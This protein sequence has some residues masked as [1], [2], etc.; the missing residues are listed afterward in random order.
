MAKGS[1]N[2][3]VK[4]K[5]VSIMKGVDSAIK[6]LHLRGLGIPKVLHS[7]LIASCHHTKHHPQATNQHQ[8]FHKW[9]LRM[10]RGHA[11]KLGTPKTAC[12]ETP[13]HWNLQFFG[14]S[15]PAKS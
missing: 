2:V 13:C 7:H 5:G 8:V 9:R 11:E 4:P 15:T 12:A 6:G 10:G 1:A 3:Y 14:P